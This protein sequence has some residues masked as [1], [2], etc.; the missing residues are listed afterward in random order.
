MRGMVVIDEVVRS[1]TSVEGSFEK[2]NNFSSRKQIKYYKQHLPNTCYVPCSVFT[3]KGT[4][5]SRN[6]IFTN[7]EINPWN[8]DVQ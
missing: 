5:K 4:K 7:M 8:G 2:E 6:E 3:G 1:L